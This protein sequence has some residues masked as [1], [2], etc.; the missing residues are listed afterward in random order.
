MYLNL[1]Y[2]RYSGDSYTWERVSN[3]LLR[4]KVGGEGADT[5]VQMVQINTKQYV[6]TCFNKF[7]ALELQYRT[8]ASM[9][10]VISFQD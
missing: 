1:K 4:M 2:G 8:K 10:N 7:V 5:R 9:C 6:M 3:M